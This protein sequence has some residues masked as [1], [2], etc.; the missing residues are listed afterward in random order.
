MA[1][2]RGR[3]R[4]PDNHMSN[5]GVIESLGSAGGAS[6]GRVRVSRCLPAG[7][8]F[9]R[10]AAAFALIAA[11]SACGGHPMRLVSPDTTAGPRYTCEPGAGRICQPATSDVPEELNRSGTV[12]VILPRECKGRVHQLVIIDAGSSEP[13]VDAT[14]APEEAPLDEMSLRERRAPRAAVDAVDAVDAVKRQR[15]QRQNQEGES[16]RANVSDH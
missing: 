6:R 16:A 15:S 13:K 14:C 3:A 1:L 11:A 4:P 10:S 9:S 12:F 8:Y 5:A 7:A 2:A